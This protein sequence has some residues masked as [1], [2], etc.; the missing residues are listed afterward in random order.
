MGFKIGEYRLIGLGG[1]IASAFLVGVCLAVF[2]FGCAIEQ[3]PDPTP[4][5]KT[6]I[7]FIL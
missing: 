6:D 7:S 1:S 2:A 4:S 5:S 3:Y